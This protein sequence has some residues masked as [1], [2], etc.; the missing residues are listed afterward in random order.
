M[1]KENRTKYV[2]LGLLSWRPMSGYDLKKAIEVSVGNFWTESYGQIYPMLRQL[3]AEG[4]TTSTVEK[5]PGKPERY[6]YT[7]TDQGREVLQQW[8]TEPVMPSAVRIELLLKLFFGQQVGVAH[9]LE[10]VRE[11]RTL[12]QNLCLKYD[13]IEAEM[14]AQHAAH[15][16]LPYWLI[17]VSYGRHTSQA[18]IRW[19]DE[20]LDELNRLATSVP[21][22]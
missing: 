16:D 22:P 19:C 20:T 12:H 14:R 7:L 2:L 3:I 10:H 11:C 18:I 5:Q 4:L 13:A 17:T 6:I 15:P 8:L 21:R 9:S 1:A